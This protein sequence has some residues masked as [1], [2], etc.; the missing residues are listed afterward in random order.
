MKRVH[1]T[2][3]KKE[4]HGRGVVLSNKKQAKRF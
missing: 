1:E 2:S 4:E 3:E